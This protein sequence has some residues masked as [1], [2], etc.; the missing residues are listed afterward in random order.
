[1]QLY[2]HLK[3]WT[4]KFKLL[5]LLN[6]ISYFDKIC[7]ICCPN[8]HIRRLKVWLASVL[9]WLKYRTFSR[10][11]FF[12]GAPCRHTTIDAVPDYSIDRVVHRLWAHTFSG[13]RD[14]GSKWN[15]TDPKEIAIK[16]LKLVRTGRKLHH[17]KENENFTLNRKRADMSI[18]RH[19][20][21]VSVLG[22]PATLP[23]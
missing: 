20:P 15:W 8:T 23:F 3:K 2:V 17:V 7:T 16:L 6:H 21:P 12:I 5:Y 19:S 22:N 4:L 18:C 10:G 1:V 14:K 9:P 11:L 13:P